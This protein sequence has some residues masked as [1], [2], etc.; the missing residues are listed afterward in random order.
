MKKT[1]TILLASLLAVVVGCA[2]YEP[3]TSMRGADVIA[4]DAVQ[5]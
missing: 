5:V 2:S 4:A 3:L 1:V